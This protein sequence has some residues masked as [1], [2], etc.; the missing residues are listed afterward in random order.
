MSNVSVQNVADER[1]LPAQWMDEL[2]KLSEKIRNKAFEL[3]EKAGHSNGHDLD[4]WFEAEKELL[5][6]P[7]TKMV[8]TATDFKAQVAVPGFDAKDIEVTALP[9]AL[10]VKAQT[11]RERKEEGGEVC[12]SESSD[13]SLF[14]RI[15]L[16]HLID[17]ASVTATTDMGLLKIVALKAAAQNEKKKRIVVTA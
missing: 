12:Y 15:P 4:H 2:Q 1:S 6:I 9:D 3:F 7:R 16:P 13:Q 8:E 17:V 11:T 5:S 14:Q 10:L